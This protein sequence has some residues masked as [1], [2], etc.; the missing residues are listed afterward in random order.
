MFTAAV[1][2]AR[3]ERPWFVVIVN[4]RRSSI[5]VLAKLLYCAPAWAGF[6]SAADH[7]RL[8]AFLRRCK[9][10]RYCEDDLSNITDLFEHADEKLFSNITMNTCFIA[11]CQSARRLVIIT[12][13]LGRENIAN[14]RLCYCRG[15]AR[16]ATSVKILWPF[17]D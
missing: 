12:T 16:R 11:V 2:T 14:N 1:C 13:T 10:L 6:C 8:D 5:N 3:S 9:R 17:F 7:E 4:A 15:T